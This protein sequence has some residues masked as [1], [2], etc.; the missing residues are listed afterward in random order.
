MEYE[1][2]HHGILGMHWGIRRYQ[3]PD[4]SLTPAGRKRYSSKEA[5]E[6]DKALNDRSKAQKSEKTSLNGLKTLDQT[7]DAIGKTVDAY[8]PKLY[9]L[10][11]KYNKAY[12]ELHWYAIQLVRSG[13]YGI[14]DPSS[15][16][17]LKELQE[18]TSKAFQVF[19]DE[20]KKTV[21]EILGDIGKE[22]TR[23]LF[24]DNKATKSDVAASLVRSYM[25][26]HLPM[27]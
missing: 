3:N 12:G 1:L 2:Y 9:Q 16:K 6:I 14:G 24:T 20:S 8:N 22:S 15:D 13:K 27:Y 23:E 19:V 18:K 17:K 5:L 4:G 25:N 11:K 21:D 7:E 10:A 26:R